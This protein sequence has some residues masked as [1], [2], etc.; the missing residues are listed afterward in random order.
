MSAGVGETLACG[1]GACAAV[2]VGRRWGLLSDQVSVSQPGGDL[3]ITCAENGQNITMS[4][5]V[6]TVFTGE[7]QI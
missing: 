7:W 1:S 2:L 5:E 3:Q 6:A 4:G